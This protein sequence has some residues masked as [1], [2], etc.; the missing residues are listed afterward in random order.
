MFQLA[1][2]L[3]M[4]VAYLSENMTSAE[5][6]GWMALYRIEHEE[7]LQ[8]RAKATATSGVEA[9]KRRRK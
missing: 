6:S 2:E 3:K 7:H 1:R 4:T 8:E 5:L 9:A